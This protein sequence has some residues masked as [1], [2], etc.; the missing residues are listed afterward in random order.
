MTHWI[1]MMV[2]PLSWFCQ[3]PEHLEMTFCSFVLSTTA[4]D[5]SFRLFVYL[6]W[7]LFFVMSFLHVPQVRLTSACLPCTPPHPHPCACQVMLRQLPLVL[8]LCQPSSPFHFTFIPQYQ[9]KHLY[10][11]TSRGHLLHLG[12]PCNTT[13]TCASAMRCLTER[14]THLQLVVWERWCCR[15]AKIPR[16]WNQQKGVHVKPF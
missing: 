11:F 7:Q 6:S 10:N 16:R 9:A 14:W 4:T 8:A 2:T 3:V 13:R 15:N 12:P 5:T 1:T